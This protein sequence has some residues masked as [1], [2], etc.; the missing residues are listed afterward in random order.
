MMQNQPQQPKKAPARLTDVKEQ[1]RI[2]RQYA[3]IFPNHI[4][5]YAEL[6]ITKHKAKTNFAR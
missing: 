1:A 6:Y 2:L 5:E 3:G 4:K